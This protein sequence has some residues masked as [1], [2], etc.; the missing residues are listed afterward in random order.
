LT[1]IDLSNRTDFPA[2]FDER[3]TLTQFLR[4]VRLTVHA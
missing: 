4:Y 1:Q 3:T 2:A